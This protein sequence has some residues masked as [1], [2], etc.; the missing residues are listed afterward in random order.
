[1]TAGGNSGATRRRAGGRLARRKLREAGPAQ[2][3]VRAGLKGGAFKPL[4]ERDVERIHQTALDV[5]AN[6]GVADPPPEMLELAL[7]KGCTAYKLPC[8]I[9]PEFEPL[10]C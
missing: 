7:A 6:V 3:P 4:S 2:A 5:L 8:V 1:M 9:R 10:V